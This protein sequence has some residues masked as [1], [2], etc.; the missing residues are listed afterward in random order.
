MDLESAIRCLK[1][2]NIRFVEPTRW[3][4]RFEGRLYR[5]NYSNV[6]TSKDQVPLLY[7]C[8]LSQ[9]ARN[10]AAWKIYTHGNTG[11]GAHCVQFKINRQRLLEQLVRASC[12]KS[13]YTIFEGKVKYL[14]ELFIRNIHKKEYDSKNGKKYNT[15]YHSHFDSF[16]LNSYLN[17]MLLK[18]D[19]FSHEQESRLFIIS[20][21]QTCNKSALYTK[22][23]KR[24]YGGELFVSIDWAEIIEEVLYDSEC[25]EIEVEILTNMCQALLSRSKYQSISDKDRKLYMKKITPKKQDIYGK[26][27]TVTIERP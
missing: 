8:C 23:G 7:A 15:Y 2:G 20:N 5:A 22:D 13:G 24:V 4:D 9:K 16:S 25:S 10:E 19:Y 18:R 14:K 12:I 1:N 3:D 11:L 17:L 21:D 27:Q 6:C 26:R